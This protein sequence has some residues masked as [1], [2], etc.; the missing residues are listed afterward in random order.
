M[1]VTFIPAGAVSNCADPVRLEWD[2]YRT[3][4]VINRGKGWCAV[5]SHI[6][7]VIFQSHPTIGGILEWGK[8][9]RVV[10][11]KDGIRL[12]GSD[13]FLDS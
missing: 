3:G 4:L 6:S 5:P 2:F 13:G 8:Q 1:Q 7:A 10:S 12:A 11:G 9:W